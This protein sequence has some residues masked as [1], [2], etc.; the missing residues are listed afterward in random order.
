MLLVKTH[1]IHVDWFQVLRKPS[2]DVEG[3]EDVWA[4]ELIL[5]GRST[6]YACI[7]GVKYKLRGQPRSQ[8]MIY[9]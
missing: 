4:G 2:G 5:T 9:R 3:R 1:K 7:A 6:L 8:H